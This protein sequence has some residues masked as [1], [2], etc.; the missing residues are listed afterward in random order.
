MPVVFKP[1]ARALRRR[2]NGGPS[3]AT[4]VV[5]EHVLKVSALLLQSV[6]LARV[7]SPADFGTFAALSLCVGLS[8]TFGDPGVSLSVVQVPTFTAR[9]ATAAL[10]T[11][12]L[13]SL[14]VSLFLGALALLA[15]TSIAGLAELPH[16]LGVI[17][18]MAA[19]TGSA[20]VPTGLLM[21]QSRFRALAAS[22]LLSTVV[23]VCAGLAYARAYGGAMT[24]FVIA[25]AGGLV[26]NVVLWSAVAPVTFGKA[27]RRSLRYLLS[28]CK[29]LVAARLIDAL[30]TGATNAAIAARVGLADLG[31]LGRADAIRQMP[32][33]LASAVT[34]RVYLAKFAD[35]FRADRQPT[36][37]VAV[38][39]HLACRN[40]MLFAMP[41]L[42]YI[43]TFASDIVR[44]L[45][46]EQWGASGKML[47]CL[48]PGAVFFLLQSLCLNFLLGIGATS[49][50]LRM[51]GVK[52][53]VLLTSLLA[54]ITGSVYAYA[55]IS[56]AAWA[57]V[58]ILYLRVM[59][60]LGVR[61]S[62]KWRVDALKFS[63]V[64][65]V[66]VAALIWLRDAMPFAYR[67]FGLL[68]SGTLLVVLSGI[69]YWFSGLL[70]W[71]HSAHENN[72]R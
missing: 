12:L 63:L 38:E 67:W 33:S 69:L 26:T 65:F 30:S 40:T 35:A 39:F 16:Y 43:F 46:G 68:V 20:A 13:S 49:G 56:S 57:V 31:L 44:L 9:L 62:L 15:P 3:S 34:G 17:A 70:R 6:I 60:R 47:M 55:I 29:P 64:T 36:G 42:A 14:M 54:L 37:A 28:R 53:V 11:A 50:Y 1:F 7:L 71:H 4:W 48:V 66:L 8:S 5:V 51:E 72:N 58:S 61:F 22:G 41:V 52:K 21:R 32:I 10:L 45:F 2:V 59:M 23:G 25:I 19:L 24:F 18:M 27:D